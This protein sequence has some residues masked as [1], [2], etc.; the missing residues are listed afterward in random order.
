MNI[1]H[2]PVQPVHKRD[3]CGGNFGHDGSPVLHL[4]LPRDQ[5]SLFEP[6]EQSRDVGI[7]GDQPVTDFSGRK[8][9]WRP[10]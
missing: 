6:V 9:V 7:P 2:R 5:A 3:A 8:P 1:L 4:A 10:P